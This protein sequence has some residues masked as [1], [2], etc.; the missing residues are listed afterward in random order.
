MFENKDFHR[1]C[2][3]L[4]ILGSPPAANNYRESKITEATLIREVAKGPLPRKRSRPEVEIQ[5]TSSVEAGKNRPVLRAHGGSKGA[6]QTQP[7]ARRR[8]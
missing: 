8:S 5:A 7:R 3:G 1:S 6:I 4:N 2:A